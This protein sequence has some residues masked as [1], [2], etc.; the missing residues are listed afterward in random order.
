MV[1]LAPAALYEL[2]APVK[3]HEKK[4][5]R[6]AESH[7]VEIGVVKFFEAKKEIVHGWLDA[8]FNWG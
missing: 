2:V 7:V 8:P 4:K 6:L 5:G 1:K 3:A